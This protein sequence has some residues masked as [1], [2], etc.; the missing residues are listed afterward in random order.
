M[1]RERR[2]RGMQLGEGMQPARGVLGT[3]V[4]QPERNC[5]FSRR[6]AALRAGLRGCAGEL[7]GEEGF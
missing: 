7:I 1:N 2:H 4:L 5:D 3:M 6:V